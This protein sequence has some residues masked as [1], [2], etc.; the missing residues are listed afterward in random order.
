MPWDIITVT[1]QPAYN[2]IEP[3]LAEAWRGANGF[4]DGACERLGTSD[5][6]S[7]INPKVRFTAQS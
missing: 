3:N 6:A 2:G 1:P 7:S 4:W 5:P